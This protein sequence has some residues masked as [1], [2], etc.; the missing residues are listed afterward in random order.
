M[1][2]RWLTP[3]SSNVHAVTINDD[4]TVDV[5]Y[6]NGGVYRY[7]SVDA[8]TKRELVLCFEVEAS[9]GKTV[10]KLLHPLPY[11]KLN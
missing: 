5:E 8:E 4:D 6:R 2:I 1:A 10:R 11:Q 7:S 9:A 3:G